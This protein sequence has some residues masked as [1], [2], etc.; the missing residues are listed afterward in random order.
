MFFRPVVREIDVE[1]FDG[2]ISHKISY[3]GSGIGANQSYVC[4]GPSAEA[5]NGPAVVSRCPFYTEKIDIGMGL[6]LEEQEGGSAGADFDVNGHLTSENTHK[7]NPAVQIF[8]L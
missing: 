2:A 7:V 5:V 4:N 8:G 6:G 1:T 3:E